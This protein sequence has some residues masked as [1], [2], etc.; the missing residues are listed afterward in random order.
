MLNK[1]KSDNSRGLINI[2]REGNTIGFDGS[3]IFDEVI[4]LMAVNLQFDVGIPYQE[5]FSMIK[6]VAFNLGEVGDIK[7]D[8]MAQELNKLQENYR[9]RPLKSISSGQVCLCTIII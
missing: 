8:E 2:Y 7:L 6:D 4:Q 1:I 3:G 9:N 5:R